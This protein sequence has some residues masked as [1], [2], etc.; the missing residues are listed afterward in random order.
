MRKLRNLDRLLVMTN[1]P[2]LTARIAEAAPDAHIE[3]V[4]NRCEAL[5][6]LTRDAWDAI[7]CDLD[8]TAERDQIALRDLAAFAPDVAYVVRTRQ[9]SFDVAV[10][11]MRLGAS[12]LITASDDAPR[13]TAVLARAVERRNERRSAALDKA[14]QAIFARQDAENLPG[15]IVSVAC[16]VMYA[17]DA[18]LMLPDGNGHLYVAHSDGL[19]EEIK[20]HALVEL[21]KGIAGAVARDRRPRIIG[22]IRG[23]VE[24]GGP[25][26]RECRK[27]RSSIVY[28][29]VSG[30]RL[31]GVLNLNRVKVLRPFGRSDLERAGVLAAHI[32]LALENAELSHAL[33]AT[34]RAAVIGQLAA[35]IAH[36]ISNPLA[37]L[38]P[39]IEEARDVFEKLDRFGALLEG[40]AS[41][42]ELARAWGGLGGS[43]T[44]RDMRDALTDARLGVHRIREV[45]TDMR[46]FLSAEAC[47]AARFDAAD[48]LRT[49]LR[50]ARVHLHSSVG[51]DLRL[52]TPL[53]LEGSPGRLADAVLSVLMYLAKGTPR[54]A[55]REE[56]IAVTA[57]RTGD[58]ISIH[59]LDA[60]STVPASDVLRIFEPQ[61]RLGSGLRTRL[62]ASREI[63]RAH[64]GEL[65]ASKCAP[66]GLQFSITLPVAAARPAD[67]KE[68]ARA[69]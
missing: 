21:G 25:R 45:V 34:E 40:G 30:M 66:R 49:A 35:G 6:A 55:T 38:S 48:A 5:A 16:Q 63:V 17:D 69:S 20:N 24:V 68:L 29:L 22:E 53:P 65:R 18:S 62:Y 31:L 26:T 28:P 19:P 23:D 15:T 1:D 58:E 64:G 11:A 67:V 54:D 46:T 51:I 60:G 61:R 14:S 59:I 41:S 33:D 50:I 44:V 10:S 37:F 47:G 57:A 2:G 43:E 52:V 42:A 4:A 56:S 9:P 12:D 8:L 32:V 13:L 27:V 7:V 3:A 39:N 36:E